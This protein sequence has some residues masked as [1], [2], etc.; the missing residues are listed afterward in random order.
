MG[1]MKI[2]PDIQKRYT[3]LVTE[4]RKHSDLYHVHDAPEISDEAYDSLVRELTELEK[5]HPDLIRA[6]SPTQQIGDR[7]KEGF[8]KVAHA[9][10]QYSFDNVFSFEELKSW[11]EKVLRM[12]EKKGISKKPTYCAELKIDGLKVILTYEKGKFIRAATRGNGE[13]GEDITTNVRTIRDIPHTLEKKDTTTVIG[14]AWMSEKEL[15]RINKERAKVDEPPFANPRNAAA[16]SLRQLDSR[17]TAV[18]KLETFIYDIDDGTQKTQIEELEHLK[19]LGFNVNK[20]YALCTTIEEIETYYQSW[21]AKRSKQDYEVDGVVIKV[22]EIELQQALGHTA[23]APRYAVAYKFPAEQVTTTIEDIVLQI[24]RTGV[25]TPV[26]HLAPVHVGGA[27]VSRATLHNE[28]FIHELDLRIG[29]TVIL[30]RAGDVIPEVVSVLKD[31]R[32]G[33]EKKW[34]FPKKVPLCG[35]DGSVERVPGQAAHR[36]VHKGGLT[37]QKRVLEHF[38]SKHAFDI[39][40]LGKE[41]V[42]L[43]LEKGLITDAADIFTLKRGDLLSLEGFKD[44]SVDNLLRSIDTSLD[45]SLARFLIGL[46]IDQVGEETAHDL[47]NHFK[48]LESIQQTSQEELEA[49]E[50]VGPIVAMSVQSWFKSKENKKLLK[51]LL[52]YVSIRENSE[53]KAQDLKLSGKTFVLTGTLQTMTRDEAKALIREKGGKIVST[54]SKNTDY[55]VAGDKPGSKYKKAQELDVKIMGEKGFVALVGQKAL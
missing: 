44:K 48:T 3:K 11:E 52:R 24:G 7:P 30:Q 45:I 38:V 5:A 41:Q 36:C 17:I 6:D 35:G 10:K 4:V 43:F 32:T 23:K 8:T 13:V 26:A 9:H 53:S 47:A 37:Q 16:G 46:S 19:H 2:S 49:I 54:V 12:L 39:E 28:D 20:D 34:V 18:R 27:T 1:D 21:I 15:K 22:N 51:K 14:E 33:R 42:R 50:G 25:L 55:V 40:G 29:D 31:V